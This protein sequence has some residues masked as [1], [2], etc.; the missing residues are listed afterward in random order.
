MLG[1]LILNG[2][3]TYAGTTTVSGGTLRVN[4]SQPASPIAVSAATLAGAGTVGPITASNSAA[5]APGSSPG[6]LSCSNVALNPGVTL[7]VELNG[8]AA[9]SG[10]DQINVSGSVSLNNAG[11]LVSAG[12]TPAVGNSFVIINNDGA[13]A[14]IGTFNSRPEGAVINVAGNAFQ[15]SY[16]GGTGNDVVLTRLSPPARFDAI[17]RLANAQMQLHATGG[18]SGFSYTI[19]AATNL[20]PVIQWSNLGTVLANGSGQFSF[21]DT[22]APL[23]PMR[24]YRALSP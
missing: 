12:F 11:L 18:L 19:A 10:Y 24:F 15:I 23:F 3:N 2:N 9:G 5:L 20:N 1:T 13:D 16:T 21:T 14:V 6:I 8:V 22:N 17:T 7:S 4:G